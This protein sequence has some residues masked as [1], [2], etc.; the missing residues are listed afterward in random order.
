MSRELARWHDDA[1]RWLVVTLMVG[2]L[3]CGRGALAPDRAHYASIAVFAAASV[4]LDAVVVGPIKVEDREGPVEK[5][6]PALARAAAAL[7]A[8]ALVIDEIE[9]RFELEEHTV[10]ERGL[11]CPV[12]RGREDTSIN[13]LHAVPK[14]DEVLV[15]T[16]RGRALRMRAK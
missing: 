12:D 14:I 10:L 9:S 15:V 3:A 2:A 5:L 8:D 11:E 16:L 4:P 1:V 6:R 13:C 7:G